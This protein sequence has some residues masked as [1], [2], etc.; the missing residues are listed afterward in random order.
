MRKGGA[1]TASKSSLGFEFNLRF[2]A[3]VVRTGNHEAEKL[4]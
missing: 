3:G 1:F 4:R 2:L